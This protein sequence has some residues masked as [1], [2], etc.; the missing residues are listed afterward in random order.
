MAAHIKNKGQGHVNNQWRTEGKKGGI[1]EKK[2]D[3]GGGNTHFVTQGCTNAK[4]LILKEKL[5]FAY[6]TLHIH[7]N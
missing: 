3:R 5:N 2:S 1:N 7:I 6:Q 4:G